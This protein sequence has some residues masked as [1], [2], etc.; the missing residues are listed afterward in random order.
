MRPRVLC[1]D[2]SDLKVLIHYE[3]DHLEDTLSLAVGLFNYCL[4][5]KVLRL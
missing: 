1:I 4:I 5:R 2:P 3:L